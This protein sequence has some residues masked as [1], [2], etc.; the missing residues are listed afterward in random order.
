MGHGSTSHAARLV[1]I[2]A[3]VSVARV[4]A[5]RVDIDFHLLEQEMQRI[6]S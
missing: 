2:T 5:L 3:S 4:L 6:H 1:A